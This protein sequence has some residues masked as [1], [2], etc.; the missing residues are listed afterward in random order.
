M[1]EHDALVAEVAEEEPVD[2]VKLPKVRPS[3]AARQDLQDLASDV[4]TFLPKTLSKQARKREQQ[5]LEETRIRVVVLKAR[6]LLEKLAADYRF[7]AKRYELTRFIQEI[8]YYESLISLPQSKGGQKVAKQAVEQFIGDLYAFIWD[9]SATGDE[10]TREL[11]AKELYP[12]E[13]EEHDWLHSLGVWL[14]KGRL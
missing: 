6:G 4:D 8:D 1:G 3:S 7:A 10:Q 2:N 11:I 13:Q 5:A 14:D 9:L 12:A